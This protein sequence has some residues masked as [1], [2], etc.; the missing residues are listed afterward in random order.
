MI[1]KGNQEPCVDWAKWLE[2]QNEK[3]PIFPLLALANFL[4]DKHGDAFKSITLEPHAYQAIDHFLGSKA[5]HG[6]HGIEIFTQSGSFYI[7][8]F[9]SRLQSP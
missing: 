7:V 9:P 4:Q 2:W 5:N 8:P 6:E 1:G 3:N